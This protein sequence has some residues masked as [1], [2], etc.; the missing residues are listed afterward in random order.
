MCM[1]KLSLQPLFL[2]TT[3]LKVSLLLCSTLFWYLI[4]SIYLIVNSKTC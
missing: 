2:K 3:S 4:T 1:I